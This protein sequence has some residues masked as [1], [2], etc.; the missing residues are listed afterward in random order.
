MQCMQIVRRF[1]FGAAM[2]ATIW[3]SQ[4]GARPTMA[5]AF[6]EAP[7]FG[8]GRSCTPSKNVDYVSEIS[9][10]DSVVPNQKTVMRVWKR[11]NGF[12]ESNFK[13]YQIDV[14]QIS[15]DLNGAG[16]FI[17]N[18]LISSDG[19]RAQLYV[20][21]QMRHP[22]TVVLSLNGN[23]AEVLR[24]FPFMTGESVNEACTMYKTSD[25]VYIDGKRTQPWA[26]RAVDTDKFMDSGKQVEGDG[27]AEFRGNLF[28]SER[29][30]QGC[31]ISFSFPKFRSVTITDYYKNGT[32]CSAW[33]DDRGILSY[34][35][36]DGHLVIRNLLNGSTTK[37]KLK[38]VELDQLAWVDFRSENLLVLRKKSGSLALFDVI[39]DRIIAEGKYKDISPDGRLAIENTEDVSGVNPRWINVVNEISSRKVLLSVPSGGANFIGPYGDVTGDFGREL[40]LRK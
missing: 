8:A 13:E 14:Q 23:K 39:H 18:S 38:N 9:P 31:K 35:S 40:Y 10:S 7:C 2:A 1:A 19:T 34:L 6:E 16:I 29:K 25:T 4:S 11:A 20:W 3:S 5:I 37:T 17:R 15:T 32:A 28:Y 22:T 26:V 36:D 27:Y 30:D 33:A 24:T 12:E 21:D